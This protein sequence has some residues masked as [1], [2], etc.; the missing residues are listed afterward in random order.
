MPPL[1][2]Q[3]TRRGIGQKGYGPAAA[4][5]EKADADQKISLITITYVIFKMQRDCNRLA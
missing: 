5:A 4:T 2:R 3:D 1:L